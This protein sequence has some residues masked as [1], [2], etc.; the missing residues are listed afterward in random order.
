MSPGSFHRVGAALALLAGSFAG[1]C[2]H[3]SAPAPERY[4]GTW[5]NAED[6]LRIDRNGLGEG[7]V[8]RGR[9]PRAFTWELGVDRITITFD[10]SKRPEVFEGRLDVDG[11]LVVS[12]PRTS[13]TLERVV[14][15]EAPAA[16]NLDASPPAGRRG[17]VGADDAPTDSDS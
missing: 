17:D 11:H 15:P 13:V 4:V 1:G 3:R 12:S 6:R 16:G 10:G 2:G 7:R 8:I 9:D 5:E 14:A